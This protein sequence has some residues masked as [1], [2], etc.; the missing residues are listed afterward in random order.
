MWL[1]IKFIYGGG[2][3]KILE[4]PSKDQPIIQD[5]ILLYNLGHDFEIPDMVTYTTKHYGMYLSQ[6]LRDICL[7]PVPKAMEAVALWPFTDDLEAG[8]IQV[9]KTE[10]GEEDPNHPRHMLIDFVL[11]GRD[12]L[13]SSATLTCAS[14][15]HK[16][17][18][19]P[20][21]SVRFCWPSTARGTRHLG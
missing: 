16:A 9:Y 2:S 4:Y 6:K 17:C 21:L 20:R 15:S 7:Y 11:A 10:L 8:I 5:Y 19:P 3:V 13:L 12:V 18:C 14:A 1:I